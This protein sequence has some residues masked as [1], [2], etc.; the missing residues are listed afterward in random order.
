MNRDV[1]TCVALVLSVAVACVVQPGTEV[2]MDW[3]L[4]PDRR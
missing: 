4:V 1:S 2:G 3:I